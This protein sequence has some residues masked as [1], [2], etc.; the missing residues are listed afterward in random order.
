MFSPSPDNKLQLSWKGIKTKLFIHGYLSGTLKIVFF[1]VFLFLLIKC[2]AVASTTPFSFDGGMN[3]QAAQNLARNFT[4]ATSYETT[5]EF[6]KVIQTGIPVILPVAIFFLLFGE[7]YTSGLMVNAIY[8]IL[9]V[10]ALVYFLKNCIKVNGL[11]VL[12]GVLFFLGTPNIFHLGFGLYGEIPMLFYVLMTLIYLHRSESSIK[13]KYIFIAGIFFGLGYLTKT[14]ILI[15]MP[16]LAFVSIYDFLV[17]H[18]FSTWGYIKQWAMFLLGSLIP[19]VAFEIF[20]L[21]SLGYPAYVTW[22]QVELH[23]ILQQAGVKAGFTDTLGISE[24]LAVHLN[25]LATYLDQPDFIIAT[26]LLVVLVFLIAVVLYGMYTRWFTRKSGRSNTFHF[27][28]DLLV[29]LI[30]TLSYFGWWLV[31]TPTTRTYY[32]RIVVGNILLEICLVCMTFLLIN[33]MEKRMERS[34]KKGY[35]WLRISIITIYMLLL[36][37]SL[38]GIARTE[39]FKISF[40]DTPIKTETLAA[41]E[42]IKSLSPGAEIY[43]YGWWQAPNIAFT[44]GKGFKNLYFRVE[45]IDTETPAEMYFVI[46]EYTSGMDPEGY[47][48]ILQKYENRLVFASHNIFIYQLIS[49]ASTVALDFIDGVSAGYP[50]FTEIEKELVAYHLIDFTAEDDL[51]I[52]SR[53][54]YMQEE[55]VYGKWAQQVSGYLL[56]FDGEGTLGIVFVAPE[57]FTYDNQP[58]ELEIYVNHELVRIYTIAQSGLHM[59]SVPLDDID[60]SPIEV[61]LFCSAKMLPGYADRELS[62]FMVKMELLK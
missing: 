34:N 6:D 13:T 60:S 54:V 43:G 3:V 44:S 62:I 51:V 17:K 4:Y 30:V 20:K 24:K 49:R 53:N 36:A 41:G 57:I 5:V 61:T 11:F 56:K 22:W 38:H 37:I 55:N 48:D 7:S 28:N 25:L 23:E 40:L 32:R 50:A 16:A 19:V 12:L 21:V 29:L 10:S 39:N 47:Q 9:T 15:A 58:V 18:R 35:Q 26:L 31:I 33:F 1:I 46:D 42:F 52:F 14:V 8:M 59:V 45:Q 2:V 27:S